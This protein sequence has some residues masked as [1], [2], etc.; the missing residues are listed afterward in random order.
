MIAAALLLM[1]AGHAVT[2]PAGTPVQ[3]AT[4]GEINSR[5][6]RQGQRFALTVT[7]DVRVGDR[8]VILRGT[9][10]VGEV[11]SLREK[12]MF[13]KAAKFSLMPLF[14]DLPG[15]RVN[16]AG[17][18]SQRGKKAVTEAAVTIREPVRAALGGRG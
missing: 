14:V 16:L 9:P 12:G 10:A 6:I 15:V 1:F 13:G 18:R 11:E 4:V 3:L 7:E 17:E 5:S 2:L 8:L